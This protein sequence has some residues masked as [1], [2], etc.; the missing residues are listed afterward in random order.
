MCGAGQ[1]LAGSRAVAAPLF[2][3]VHV[4]VGSSGE[5]VERVVFAEA[6]HAD[7]DR[8]PDRSPRDGSA[9]L[10]NVAVRC[11]EFGICEPAEELIAADTH[12]EVVG[13]QLGLERVRSGGLMVRLEQ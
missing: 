3:R 4:G 13:A 10:L 6:G 2:V 5:F 11:V 1:V 12:D 8:T 7:G 9:E